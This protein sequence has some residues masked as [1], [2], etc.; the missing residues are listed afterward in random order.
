MEYIFDNKFSEEDV[1]LLNE[2]VNFVLEKNFKDNN[3]LIL[4]NFLKNL[5]LLKSAVIK[6]SKLIS[7]YILQDDREPLDDK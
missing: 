2:E 3:Y 6:R 1:N 7:N 4:I 5:N